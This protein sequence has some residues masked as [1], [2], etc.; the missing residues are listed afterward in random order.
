MVK[1]CGAK[2]EPILKNLEKQKNI[3]HGKEKTLKHIIIKSIN[4]IKN[5]N[6]K[7]RGVE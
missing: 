4:M 5:I 7:K 6:K 1:Y 3:R 2:I